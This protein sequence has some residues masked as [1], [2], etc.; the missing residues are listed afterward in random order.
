[1]PENGRI[2]C[3]IVDS[4]NITLSPAGEEHPDHEHLQTC[5]AYHQ[6]TLHKTEVEDALLGAPDS[7]E[8]SVLSRAEILLLPRQCRDLARQLEYCLL[9]AAQLLGRGPGFLRQACSRLVLNLRRVRCRP[10]CWC[11]Y[12]LTA[13]S[14]STTLSENVDT[15]LSKQNRYSPAS[16]AVNT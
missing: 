11:V 14:K 9:Y 2:K 10:R 15:E 1:M 16:F 13:I 7:A 5:H 3:Y 4:S 8:I 6:S 12:W